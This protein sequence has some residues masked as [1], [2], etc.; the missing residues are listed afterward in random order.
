MFADLEKETMKELFKKAF[1]MAVGAGLGIL[2]VYTG[3]LMFCS[4]FI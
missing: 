3:A 4:L 2:V 1:I